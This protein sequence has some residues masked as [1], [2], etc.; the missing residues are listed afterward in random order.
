MN[1]RH[2]IHM[3]HHVGEDLGNPATGL[4]FLLKLERR[5]H[6]G[7]DFPRKETCE[8]IETLEFLP[9]VL[10][11]GGLVIPGVNLALAAIHEQP[12]H[13]LGLGREVSLPGSEGVQCKIGR[14]LHLVFL[15]QVCKGEHADTLAGTTQEIAPASKAGVRIEMGYV[16]ECH[17]MIL[18][19]R[20]KQIH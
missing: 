8:L 4:A 13:R 10:F 18:V 16:I 19:N 2:V 1:E 20:E 5:L 12:D 7:A 9:I 14:G 15:K 6:Q 17:G 11:K 3:I